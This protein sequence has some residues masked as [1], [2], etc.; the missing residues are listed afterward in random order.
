ML[1]ITKELVELAY[2]FF[3]LGMIFVTTFCLMFLTIM[4][5][6]KVVKLNLECILLGL[7]A[8][9]LYVPSFFTATPIGLTLHILR[10]IILIALSCGLLTSIYIFI[11]NNFS[12]KDCWIGNG[13]KQIFLKIN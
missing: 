4:S 12:K 7:V 1:F 11:K 9:L 10:F 13:N 8:T 3:S 2:V 6:G 5:N